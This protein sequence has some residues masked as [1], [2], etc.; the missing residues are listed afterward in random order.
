MNDDIKSRLLDELR[1]PVYAGLSES[2]AYSLLND[3]Q[4]VTET[5]SKPLTVAGVMSALSQASIAKLLP[6]PC[7]ID[8]RDKIQSQDSEGVGLWAQVLAMGG[9]ITQQE[10][11]SVMASLDET[12][13][14]VTGEKPPRINTEFGGVTGMPNRLKQADFAELWAEVTHG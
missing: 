9:V 4:P 8:V 5:R 1:S 3:P 6:L 2:A 14:V 10:A 13:D 11:G 7:L 12:E